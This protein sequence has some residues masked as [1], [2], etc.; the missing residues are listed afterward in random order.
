M[1]KVTHFRIH[2]DGWDKDR[3]LSTC[4]EQMFFNMSGCP[5]SALCERCERRILFVKGRLRSQGIKFNEITTASGHLCFGFAN[6]EG[7][8]PFNPCEFIESLLEAKIKVYH[9]WQSVLGIDEEDLWSTD[10]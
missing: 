9:M 2:I 7:V 4:G 5:V 8:D 3:F 1:I 10:D 6:P